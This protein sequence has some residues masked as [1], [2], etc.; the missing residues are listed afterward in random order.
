M[1]PI[2]VTVTDT[3]A[4]AS[5]GTGT[6]AADNVERPAWAPDRENDPS[7]RWS[8]LQ[9]RLDGTDERSST[10]TEEPL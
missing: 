8:A 10:S 5:V 3:G 1:G 9:A 2:Q 6:A 7:S 4:G